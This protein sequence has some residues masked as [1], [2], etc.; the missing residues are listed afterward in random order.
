LDSRY[1]GF[2]PESHVVGSPAL[3]WF[4]KSQYKSFPKSIRWKRMFKFV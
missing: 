3:I 4:S 2:V 1:W